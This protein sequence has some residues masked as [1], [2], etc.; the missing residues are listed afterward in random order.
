MS[1]EDNK[2]EFQG[3]KVDRDFLI[4]HYKRAE[5]FVRHWTPTIWSVPSVAFVIN[6]GTYSTIFDIGKSFECLSLVTILVILILLN[7][8][9]TVGVHKHNQGQKAF[10]NRL[11]EIER[12][13]MNIEPIKIPRGPGSAA[14]FYVF[15]MIFMTC[16][17]LV[18]LVLILSGHV[19]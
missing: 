4:E 1:T 16:I 6:L 10:G 15:A 5:S 13:V 17:S 9:L 11:M 8:A 19:S 14:N 2:V 7:I 18:V 3:E 12:K